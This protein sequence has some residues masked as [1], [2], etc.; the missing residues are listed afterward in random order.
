MITD[1]PTIKRF[2]HYQSDKHFS[3]FYLQDGGK[4]QLAWIWNDCY[5]TVTKLVVFII[6]SLF[7]FLQIR[8]T[9]A[10]LFFSWTDSTDSPDC[11]LILLSISVFLLFSFFLFSTFSSWFRAVD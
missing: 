3:E 4:N 1:L 6:P 2:K 5:V 10:F 11:L 9:V 8:P 7:P